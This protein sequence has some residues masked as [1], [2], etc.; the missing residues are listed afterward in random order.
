MCFF[1]FITLQ[2][3]KKKTIQHKLSGM[4]KI[5]SVIVLSMVDGSFIIYIYLPLLH[6]YNNT[7]MIIDL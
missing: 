5:C 3:S 1:S 4:T 6:R 2:F 7:L